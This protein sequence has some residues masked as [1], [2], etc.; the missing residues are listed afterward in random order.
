M[1]IRYDKKLN[2]EINRTIKNFNQKIARLEKEE[3][4][5]LPN[6]V[7]VKNIKK[8]AKNRKEL[9]KILR[10]LQLFSKRGSENIITLG[11]SLSTKYNESLIKR[12]IAAAKNKLTRELNKL[13]NTNIKN[14][15][16]IEA[17]TFKSMG[18]D[19]FLKLEA[20]RKALNKDITKL[21][22]KEFER[23][24][25]LVSSINNPKYNEQL[26]ENIITIIDTLGEVFS[27]DKNKINSLKNKLNDLSDAD[28][29]KLYTQDKA[30]K[31]LIDYYLNLKNPEA[32]KGDVENLLGGLYDNIDVMIA[33]IA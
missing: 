6:K 5:L 4:M 28:F 22:K 13:S 1:A 18:D 27:Y 21:D 11:E 16:K 24:I 17:G 20:R 14:L 8:E 9:Y 7:Y 2:N 3:R 32:I 29:Y 33:Q 30:I 10:N 12:D 15:G 23:L 26:K 31:A 25:N 19:Y